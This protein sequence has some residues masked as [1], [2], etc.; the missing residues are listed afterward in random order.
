MTR[1]GSL[2]A[3]HSASQLKDGG[4]NPTP[5]LHFEWCE[6]DFAAYYN[7]LWHSRLPDCRNYK[8]ATVTCV[9]TVNGEPCCVAIWGHPVARLL[10]Q[11]TW[12]E[13]RRLAVG[14][15]APR[16]TASQFIGWM[17]RWIRKNRPEIIHL[18]SYQDTAVH[19]GTIYKASGWVCMGKTRH[20]GGKGWENRPGGSEG[21][22]GK[23]VKFRWDLLL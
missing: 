17:T 15:N 11:K 7:K 20:G 16:N 13:L 10:P 18:I 21:H 2:K 6:R 3:E 23:S 19:K 12:L 9:G 1:A 22:G 4:S 8:T 5:A 14:P